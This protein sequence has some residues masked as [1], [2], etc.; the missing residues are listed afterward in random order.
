MREER[1]LRV[2]KNRVLRKIFGPE[3]DEVM[4]EFRG[5]YSEELYVQCS[6]NIWMIKSNRMRWVGH[7]AHMRD[8]RGF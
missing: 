1:R 5:L 4:R 3:R 2:F 8:R 7:V 6:P